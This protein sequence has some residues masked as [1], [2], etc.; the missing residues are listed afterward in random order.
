MKIN[1]LC[2]A[3]FLVF[4]LLSCTTKQDRFLLEK[5]NIQ[6]YLSLEKE[7]NSK[8][9]T[10][11]KNERL[12]IAF[13]PIDTNLTFT[14]PIGFERIDFEDMPMYSRAYT[15]SLGNCIIIYEWDKV[16]PTMSQDQKDKIKREFEK[17]NQDYVNKYNHLTAKITEALGP[18]IT[19]DKKLQASEMEVY[20]FWKCSQIWKKGKQTVELNLILMPNE[21]YRIIVKVL[22]LKGK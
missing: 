17:H 18:P 4:A 16:T 12:P 14:S 7:L 8:Q 21:L 20:T 2:I 3:A 9:I 1:K 19:A 22:V 11:S 5:A 6:Q 10:H 13:L 15:D